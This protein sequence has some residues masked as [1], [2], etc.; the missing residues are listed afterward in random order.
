VTSNEMERSILIHGIRLKKM[1]KFSV[2]IDCDKA[3][4]R[5]EYLPNTN[6]ALPLH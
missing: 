5:T 4:I 1:G 3:E 2:T 6:L